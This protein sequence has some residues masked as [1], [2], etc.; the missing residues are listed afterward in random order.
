MLYFTEKSGDHKEQ[1]HQDLRTIFCHLVDAC[2]SS[3]L[4]SLSF[5]HVS[6]SL[7][8]QPLNACPWLTQAALPIL[9]PLGFP[10]LPQALIKVFSPKI[11]FF[12]KQI[13]MPD[14]PVIAFSFSPPPNICK[15]VEGLA[16]VEA[17]PAT[18]RCN[19]GQ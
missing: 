6:P 1:V 10:F 11:I 3:T 15:K 16:P 19:S 12:I 18:N 17:A 9:R 2:P 7:S 5:S 8:K 13:L 4:P 14:V